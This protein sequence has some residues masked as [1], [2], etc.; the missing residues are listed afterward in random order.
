MTCGRY[1]CRPELLQSSGAPRSPG[2]A[3]VLPRGGEALPLAHTHRPRPSPAGQERRKER[4]SGTRAAGWAAFRQTRPSRSLRDRAVRGV[5]CVRTEGKHLPPAMACSRGAAKG[6]STS[7]ACV[8]LQRGCV[9]VPFSPCN[10][11]NGSCSRETRRTPPRLA[12]WAP[13]ARQLRSRKGQRLPSYDRGSG[14]AA[15]ICVE[16]DFL[17]GPAPGATEKCRQDGSSVPWGPA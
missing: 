3:R 17:A 16:T 14:T 7:G 5:R 12:S 9:H 11:P 15:L 1:K 2:S 13:R 4:M 8:G 6:N 10:A